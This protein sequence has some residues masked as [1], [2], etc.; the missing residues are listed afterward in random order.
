MSLIQKYSSIRPIDNEAATREAF[1]A[2]ARDGRMG[3]E[4][5]LIDDGR[6]G[7]LFLKRIRHG[8]DDAF[9]EVVPSS[10]HEDSM[11]TLY[12]PHP[13]FNSRAEL[14]RARH[15]LI[16]CI[17]DLKEAMPGTLMVVCPSRKRPARLAELSTRQLFDLLADMVRGRGH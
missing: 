5:H 17:E 2:L 4:P 13:C 6:S 14:M 12:A 3:M 16:E 7:V 9:L 10:V 8:D 15:E 11:M 1:T